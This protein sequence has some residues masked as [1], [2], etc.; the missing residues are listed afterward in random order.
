MGSNI[1]EKKKDLPVERTVR[2]VRGGAQICKRM[3]GETE[4]ETETEAASEDVEFAMAGNLR[5]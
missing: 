2:V 3:E 1:R 4:T 5:Q